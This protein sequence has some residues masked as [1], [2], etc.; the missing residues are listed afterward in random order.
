MTFIIFLLMYS[1]FICKTIAKIVFIFQIIVFFAIFAV[2]SCGVV[3]AALVAP[4]ASSYNAHV[5]NHA[6]AAPVAAPLVAAPFAP[7]AAPLT[8]GSVPYAYPNAYTTAF[9][10]R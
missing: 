10:G 3:P 8:Y 9:Y 4:Y 2:A 1:F 6:V 7:V 5:V